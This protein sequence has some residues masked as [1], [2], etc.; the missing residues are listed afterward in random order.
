MTTTGLTPPPAAVREPGRSWRR[1]FALLWAGSASSSLGS[2]T[3]GLAFPLMALHQ[4]GS[5]ATAGWIAALGMVPPTLLHIPIGL[6]VDRR[7]PRAIIIASHAV[8]IVC[9][10]GLV[11]PVLRLDAPL[12]LLGAA[13]AMHG[14]CATCHSTAA[15]TAVPYLVP[16][17]EL[18]GAVAKNE[19]RTHATQLAG[20][21]LGGGLFAVAAGLPALCDVLLST[22]SLWLAWRLP[23]IRPARSAA[24]GV[25]LLGDLSQGFGQL[26]RDRFLL[27]TTV[28]ATI[29][30]ALFQMIWLVILTLTTQEGL[31]AFLLGVILAASGAGGLLGSALAPRLVRR[32]RPATMVTLCLWA[33]TGVTALLAL[34]DHTDTAWLLATLPVTW[35][36]VGFVGA[37]LNVTVL[38]YHSTHLPPEV[39]GRVTGTLRFF[40]AGARPVGV[41]LGGYLLEGAGVRPT[42]G[43]ITAV[44]AVLAVAFTAATLPARPEPPAPTAT[45]E[46]SLS[47]MGGGR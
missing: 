35:C 3:L 29:T 13:A 28:A 10:V 33:W 43:A 18:A 4:T 6:L 22:L 5:P 47:R 20:R 14:V 30:N 42:T 38:T 32:H 8:R 25:R 36:G 1:D 17:A 41:L 44:I 19:A 45:P 11:G 12:A 23:P 31:S 24:D 2:I 34:A 15:T 21:P 26:R 9:V 37:H 46:L 27:L 7:D 40:S 16:R 39:L